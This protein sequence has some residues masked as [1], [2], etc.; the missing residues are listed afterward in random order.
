MNKKKISQLPLKLLSNIQSCHFYSLI[1]FSLGYLSHQLPRIDFVSLNTF[2]LNLD[3]KFKVYKSV[4]EVVNFSV[5]VLQNSN[6]AK[7]Q[8]L[9]HIKPQICLSPLN[10]ISAISVNGCNESGAPQEEISQRRIRIQ[11][12][13][14]HHAAQ[15]GQTHN[16]FPSKGL[17]SIGPTFANFG[18]VKHIV[19]SV[20]LEVVT[21]V[22]KNR[23]VNS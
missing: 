22:C 13:I 5:G 10:W 18:F 1:Q 7:T 23:R 21:Y 11:C 6:S 15:A 2:L 4:L 8:I 20:S 16:T 9:H 14:I 3:N 12:N 19:W 17:E